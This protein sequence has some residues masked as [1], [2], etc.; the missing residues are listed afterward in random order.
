MGL[1][2]FLL[3]VAGTV[4]PTPCLSASA[5]CPLCLSDD[6][7]QQLARARSQILGKMFGE[8]RAVPTQSGFLDSSS[9]TATPSLKRDLARFLLSETFRRSDRQVVVEL[10][11]WIGDTSIVL[12]AAAPGQVVYLDVSTPYLKIGADRIRALDQNVS[13]WLSS[14]SAVDARLLHAAPRCAHLIVSDGGQYAHEM[15]SVYARS[16][17]MP[18]VFTLVCSYSHYIHI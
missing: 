8:W 4:F 9:L 14:S 17:L 11:C 12:A 2:L 18:E 10:G 13:Q 3:A 15:L 5:K 7:D 1:A 16:S 6:A